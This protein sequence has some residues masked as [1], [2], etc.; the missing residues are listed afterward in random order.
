MT[1]MKNFEIQGAGVGL[2]GV[3]VAALTAA[4]LLSACGGGGGNPGAPGTPVGNTGTGTGTVTV[5]APASVQFVLATPADKSIVIQGQGGNGRTETA[6]LTFKVVDTFGNPLAGQ[7]VDFTT[8]SADVVLNNKNGKTDA[9]GQVVM[10]VNSGSKPA[11]FRVQAT[12]PGTAAN[13]KAEISTLSDTIVVTTG[14]PTQRSFSMSADIFNVEGWDFDSSPSTAAAHLQVL[15]ADAFGNPVPDGT[16]IV[17]Q[18]NAGSV[19]SS[20]RGGCNTV[21]GGCSVDFRAQNPRVPTP[22]L[23]AT[24]CNSTGTD[25]KGKGISQDAARP[26]VA[27]V[28]ASATDGTST[29]FGKAEIF[30]SGSEVRNIYLDSVNNPLDLSKPLNLGS[31]AAGVTKTFWLQL[32]DVNQNPMPAGSTVSV[33]GLSN[34]TAA[35]VAPAKVPNVGL[36]SSA[37]KDPSGA[38]GYAQGSWHKFQITGT[39]GGSCAGTA[40]Q[41][42]HF[43]VTVTT[44]GTMAS[45]AT[46]ATTT[47]IPFT[48]SVT[49]P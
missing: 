20:D 42:A 26:G 17:F 36:Y 34:A 49:C 27:T 8:T 43:N 14:L 13:G 11:T 41:E 10:T 16:A 28:C 40:S 48:L 35:A 46:G 25:G 32:N 5:G 6:T 44:P 18:T 2:R 4:L 45:A 31:V 21:N 29:L 38:S 9:A 22:G 3:G 24:V 1:E 19:G 37:T 30:L 15:L 12:L 33:T 39:S 23:P 47:D 7:Q